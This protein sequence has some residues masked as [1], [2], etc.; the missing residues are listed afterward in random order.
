MNI[1]LSPREWSRFA[2]LS[3]RLP[4]LPDINTIAR[5][6]YIRLGL[7]GLAVALVAGV[8]I[9]LAGWRQV[10]DEA[11]DQPAR[12]M[13]IADP[14]PQASSTAPA[15]SSSTVPVA[16]ASIDGLKIL[17]QHWRRAGLGSKALFTFTLRNSNDYAVRDIAISCAFSRGDG[18]HLTDRSRIIHDTVR[19]G[20]RKTFTGIHVGFVNV[21]AERAKC[22][23]IGANRI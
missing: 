1:G 5:S 20:A 17:S 10:P 16:M 19:T 8:G 6:R 23:P 14:A 2:G 15:Q 12:L 11:E 21:N 3:N 9:E 4:R 7:A 22:A 18:S 13:A